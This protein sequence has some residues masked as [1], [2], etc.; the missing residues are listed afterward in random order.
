MQRQWSDKES[1]L[2]TSALSGKS[3]YW[4]ATLGQAQSSICLGWCHFVQSHT[5][6]QGL[7]DYRH[8]TFSIFTQLFYRAISFFLWHLT[9]GTDCFFFVWPKKAVTRCKDIIDI[10]V[11]VFFSSCTYSNIL[12]YL[13]KHNYYDTIQWQVICFPPYFLHL[14]SI[15]FLF[16]VTPFCIHY[17]V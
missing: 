7:S 6:Y 11:N 16:I 12:H 15:V 17:W 10:S 4:V 5:S 8:N 13:C 2:L 1:L 9:L 3:A 14:N